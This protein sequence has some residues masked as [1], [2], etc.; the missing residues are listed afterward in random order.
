MSVSVLL[1]THKGIGDA[2][3][4]AVTRT[5]GKLPLK[6]RAASIDYRSDP[7]LMVKK[8][9]KLADKIEHGQGLL[10]LTDLFGSTPSN[11]AQHIEHGKNVRIVSGLNLPMLIRVMNYHQLSLAQLEQKA[12]TGGKDGIVACETEDTE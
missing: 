2:L 1:V 7:D 9:S 4:K 5:F 12:L 8:V 10:V 11:I 6:A 3:L